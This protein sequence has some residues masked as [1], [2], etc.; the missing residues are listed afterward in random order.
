MHCWCAA[1]LLDFYLESLSAAR[2]A[3]GASDEVVARYTRETALRHYRL[4]VLDYGRF[5]AARFWTAASPEAFAAKASNPNT[6]LVNRSTD[7]ALRFVERIDA[8]LSTFEAEAAAA[9]AADGAPP[10]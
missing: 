4:A 3:R 1:R 8:C 6:T 7:A 10:S 2:K 9:E 5:V